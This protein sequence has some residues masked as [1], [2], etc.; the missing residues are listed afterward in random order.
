MAGSHRALGE[1]TR[2]TLREVLR[3]VPKASAVAEC[4]R[5]RYTFGRRPAGSAPPPPAAQTGT[6][7]RYMP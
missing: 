5:C 7:P 2:R 3:R 4:P 6:F 1:R